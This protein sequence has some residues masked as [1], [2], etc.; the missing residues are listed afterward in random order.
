M[1][2]RINYS[3]EVLK[4]DLSFIEGKQVKKILIKIDKILSSTPK[5]YGNSI[6]TLKGNLEGLFRLRVGDYRVIYKI[7]EESN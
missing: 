7:F 6:R 3:E 5:E 2:F 1:N 4:K